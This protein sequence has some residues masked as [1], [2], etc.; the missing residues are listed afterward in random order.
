M[1]FPA[2]FMKFVR[3]CFKVIVIAYQHLLHNDGALNVAKIHRNVGGFLCQT[4]SNP[5]KY[6]AVHVSLGRCPPDLGI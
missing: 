2:K 6:G 1:N 5:G 4:G 3:L